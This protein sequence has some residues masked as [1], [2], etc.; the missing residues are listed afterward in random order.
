M[1]VQF[2]RQKMKASRKYFFINSQQNNFQN[3]TEYLIKK[4]IALRI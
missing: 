4:Y 2:Y 1:Y 3:K